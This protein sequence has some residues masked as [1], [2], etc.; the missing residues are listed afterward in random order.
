MRACLLAFFLLACNDDATR[1]S[2]LAASQGNDLAV[3]GAADLAVPDLATMPD[4]A[5]PDLR[6]PPDL[7]LANSDLSTFTVEL[8]TTAP[9]ADY[10]FTDAI[11]NTFYQSKKH[12]LIYLASDLTAAGVPA[13]A[14]IVGIAL[15]PSEVPGRQID[16]FRVALA[17]TA[18]APDPSTTNFPRPFYVA[19]P[20]V[21]YGPTDQP[22]SRFV[23]GSFT[24]FDTQPFVWD[25]TSNLLVELSFTLAVDNVAAG[26]VSMRGVARPNAY[27]LYHTHGS[28]PYPFTGISALDGVD[29]LPAI[30]IVSY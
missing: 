21:V 19:S 26:G 8:L 6:A 24:R 28:V 22:T 5:V 13:G 3:G 20:T 17:N 15:K 23:V 10:N 7:R 4:S 11:F 16:S 30:Q 2:D 14:K 18:V 9:L 27:D 29:K 12:Q 1:G 25:G